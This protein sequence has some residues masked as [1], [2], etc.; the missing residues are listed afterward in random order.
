M[1]M[2]PS[3]SGTKQVSGTLKSL[4]NRLHAMLA[5]QPTARWDV[6]LGGALQPDAPSSEAAGER[7]KA[8]ERIMRKADFS[9]KISTA[10]WL[11]LENNHNGAIALY[12]RIAVDHP[13]RIG[14]CLRSIG[15]AHYFLG[16]YETAI[17]FYEKALGRGED[18]EIIAADI[19]EARDAIVMRDQGRR[20]AA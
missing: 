19:A 6:V 10:D 2:A 20:E 8:M 12:D 1:I 11:L 9:T 4:L 17:E 15:A 3:I 5:K 7:Q 13:D 14:F 16:D 18:A